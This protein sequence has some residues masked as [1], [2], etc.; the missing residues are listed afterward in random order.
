VKFIKPRTSAE[1][2]AI[3]GP[4][5]FALFAAVFVLSLLYFGSGHKAKAQTTANL[6]DM[7]ITTVGTAAVVQIIGTNPAR[8]SL[9]ICT[10][11][12]PIWWAPVNP[13]GMTPVTPAANNGI[14]IAAG[15]CFISPA[16]AGG[17]GAAINAI[18]TGGNAIVSVLEY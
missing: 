3:F 15:T 5:A 18:S 17:M 9:Q 4:P 2:A 8:R 6:P 12:N 13:P 7:V 11:T 10:A 14:L 16:L 1:F